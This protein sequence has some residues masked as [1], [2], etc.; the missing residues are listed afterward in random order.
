MP[1]GAIIGAGAS[2]LGGASQASAAK[3]AAASQEAAAREEL[4]LQ[5]RIYDETSQNFAPYLQGGGL[6]FQAYLS[7]MGLGNAPMIG[8]MPA[9]IETFTTPGTPAT[10]G[11][12]YTQGPG[13]RPDD[14]IYNQGTAA[15]PGVTQYRVNGQTFADMGAAQEYANANP[16]GGRD[17]GGFQNTPGYSFAL[18]QG[19]DTL[20][21]TAAARGG[22][23]SGAALADAQRLG[24]GMQNQEYN[25][26]L[27][28]LQGI[29]QQGQAA[30]GN[31]AAAGA[32]Y[33]NA[34]GNALGNIGNAQ[35]AGAIGVGNAI[36]GG[37]NNAL[38][39]WQY[40]RAQQPAQAPAQGANSNWLFGGNTFGN[41]AWG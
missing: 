22:L 23:F 21:S 30:A 20:Q 1:I 2:L 4:A 29:G 9:Q 3:K 25:N 32:N 41:S 34:A 33:G 24:Q 38:G 37:I 15:I 5:T 28:R 26:Y 12:G 40:M 36:S 17:F 16:T 27:N 7:E 19:L 8:G 14:R 11:G 39:A 10:G 13:G 18:G 31:Q 35:S 6:G